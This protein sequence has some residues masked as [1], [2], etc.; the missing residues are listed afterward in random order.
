MNMKNKTI[1][2]VILGIL[3]GAISMM[4]LSIKAHTSSEPGVDLLYEA[5]PQGGYGT[6]NQN[7]DN[8][9]GGS[10]GFGWD[11]RGGGGGGINGYVTTDPEV[12]E[13]IDRITSDY[14]GQL[15][16][17]KLAEVLVELSK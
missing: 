5:R 6:I 1:Y 17:E 3:I 15:S 7:F 13:M 9:A 16:I 4:G 10:G 2:L 14:G 8:G 11:N 12:T